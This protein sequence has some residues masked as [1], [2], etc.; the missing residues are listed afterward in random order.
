MKSRLVPRTITVESNLKLFGLEQGRSEGS[1]VSIAF[2]VPEDMDEKELQ[3]SMYLEK[4]GLDQAVLVMERVKGSLNDGMH[5]QSRDRIKLAYDKILKRG[6]V[7]PP[8]LPEGE[9]NAGN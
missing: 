6:A 1:S 7:V 2:E 3:R 5:K 4:E 9:S 8:V